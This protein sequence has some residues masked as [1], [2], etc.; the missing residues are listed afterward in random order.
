MN[1]GMD[2]WVSFSFTHPS[3]LHL[4]TKFM[5]KNQLRTIVSTWCKQVPITY[6]LFGL[7]Q[8]NMIFEFLLSRRIRWCPGF[9]Y[10]ALLSLRN[11]QKIYGIFSTIRTYAPNVF[12]ALYC[13]F[14]LV[15]LCPVFADPVTYRNLVQEKSTRNFDNKETQSFAIHFLWKRLIMLTNSFIYCDMYGLFRIRHQIL[16]AQSWV[17]LTRYSE[18]L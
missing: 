17:I 12:N 4:K 11:V 3:S 15:Q 7:L 1:K 13:K 5:K 8:R 14:K 9:C 2:Y 16:L 6:E 10:H 18:D